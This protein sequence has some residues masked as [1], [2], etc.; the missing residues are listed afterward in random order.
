MKRSWVPIRDPARGT[1]LA[2]DW[3]WPTGGSS[4]ERFD[5]SRHFRTKPLHLTLFQTC[6]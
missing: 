6:R 4:R 3:A 5:G 1:T 2:R